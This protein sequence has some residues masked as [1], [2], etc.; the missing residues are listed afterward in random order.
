M[1][2]F[3]E[4]WDGVSRKQPINEAVK[5]GLGIKDNAVMIAKEPYVGLSHNTFKGHWYRTRKVAEIARDMILEWGKK[6]KIDFTKGSKEVGERLAAMQDK[7]V[8]ASKELEA[9]KQKAYDEYNRR[10]SL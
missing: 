9:I 4:N 2:H 10:V 6:H 1:K 7:G 5:G 3:N 8:A